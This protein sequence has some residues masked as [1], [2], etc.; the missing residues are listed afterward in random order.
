MLF[1]VVAWR[2][3]V[4]FWLLAKAAEVLRKLPEILASHVGY[5]FKRR[6]LEVLETSMIEHFA[7]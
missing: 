5:C 7:H 4:D 1:V 2:T 3:A 6:W